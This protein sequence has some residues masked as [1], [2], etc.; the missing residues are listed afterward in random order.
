MLGECFLLLLQLNLKI[1]KRINLFDYFYQIQLEKIMKNKKTLVLG[2]T[3]K[4]E[5]YAFKAVNMLI[6]KGHS[7]LALGQNAGEVAGVK[8]QTKAIPL[9]NIDTVTLYLNPTRQRDYYNY[10]VEAKPKRVIFNPGTEN[11][12][13]YQLLKLNDIK[14]EVACTLVLLATNQY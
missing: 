3:T 11:P 10:I 6:E 12:E 5:R 9:K 13:F 8:I 1:T 4:P 7:V 14:V 2:A